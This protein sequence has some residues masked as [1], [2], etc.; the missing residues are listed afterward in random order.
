MHKG[1]WRVNIKQQVESIGNQKG[2]LGKVVDRSR[3]EKRAKH[4]SEKS[5]T[6]LVFGA[7][8]PK[9]PCSIAG[10][11]TVAIKSMWGFDTVAKNFKRHMVSLSKKNQC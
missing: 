7:K 11:Q 3:A 9:E 4:L 6:V 2:H 5:S 1:A 8:V 10:K